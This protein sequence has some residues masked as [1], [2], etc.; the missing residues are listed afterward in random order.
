[1][2]LSHT[3]RH[4]GTLAVCEIYNASEK[5]KISCPFSTSKSRPRKGKKAF[6]CEAAADLA[7]NEE[8]L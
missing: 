8:I 3:I 7:L 2:C 5:K 6:G 4:L 1:M